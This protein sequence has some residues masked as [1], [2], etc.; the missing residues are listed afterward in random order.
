MVMVKLNINSHFDISSKLIENKWTAHEKWL[1]PIDKNS[2][3][4]SPYTSEIQLKKFSEFVN[5]LPKALK[6]VGNML[7]FE[8]TH[9]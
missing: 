1:Q 2:R 6:S 8:T 9:Y 5:Y 7:E 3:T 4:L